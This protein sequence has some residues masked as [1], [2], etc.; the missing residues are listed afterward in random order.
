MAST[1][2]LL[3]I[4][5]LGA[6]ASAFGACASPAVQ[7]CGKSGVYCP[8]GTHCAA[9]QGICIPDANTCGDGHLD[10][11]E[12]CDDGNTLDG[13]GC[14]RDCKSDESCGNGQVDPTAHI[15]EQCDDGPNNSKL[16]D[17]CSAACQLVKCGNGV[18]EQGEQCDDSNITSGDGCS[19]TCQRE[20]CGNG[21]TDIAA[22]EVCD[23]GD[24]NGTPGDPCSANCRS[25]L[26]CGNKNVDPGEECDNGQV[27][28][29][30]LTGN[31]DGNDCR[32]D[33]Q[34]N[35]CGDGFIDTEPGSRQEECDDGHLDQLVPVPTETAGCNI[36]C[37]KE[38]CG[39]GK[40]NR[41]AGEQ[42]DDGNTTNN[43][44]CS[45]TCQ[46][47][48][49]G[50]GLLDPQEEC[51]GSAGLQPCN[52]QTCLQERCGNGIL[53]DDAR[54]GVHEQCDDHNTNNNDGCSSTCVIEFCGDGVTN[55]HEPCDPA[56]PQFGLA[57]CNTDCT[58][59]S[60]GD[61]KLNHAAG[62]QCDDGNTI[63]GDGC[64]ATC[65]FERCGNGVLD[66]EEQC[67][68]TLGLQPCNTQTCLQEI[69]GNGILD[70]DNAAGVH[71]QCD[72]GN[73]APG[74]GCSPTCQFEF[75]GDGIVSKGEACDRALTPATCNLDCTLSSCG[76]G[77]LNTSAAPPEQ[78][79]DGGATSGDGCSA[80]CQLEH[81]GN[82]VVDAFEECD[83]AAGLQPC[84]ASCHQERCG[85]G[86]LDRD[87]ANGI[88]EQCDDGNTANGDGCSATC[89]LERCGN[90]VLDPQEQCDGTLG[91]QPCNTQTCL[92]EICGNGILDRDSANGI[93][94]QCDDANTAP[95][96]GCSPDCHFETCGNGIKD[97]GE[98]CDDGTNNGTLSSQ[99]STTCHTIKCGNGVLEQG[100]DCDDNNQITENCP[101]GAT[102]C[103][104]CDKSCKITDGTTSLCG[105]GIV[106]MA[107]ACDDGNTSCGA[108]SSDCKAVTSEFALG[109]IVVPT[110]DHFQTGDT[111]V[112]SDGGTVAIFEFTVV[113]DA[114]PAPISP[115]LDIIP[116]TITN[117]A[118]NGPELSKDIATAIA[119]AIDAILQITATPQSQADGTTLI[120]LRHRFKTSNGNQPIVSQF[121][122]NPSAFQV[123]GMAGGR[124]GNCAATQACTQDADCASTH[125]VL[126]IIGPSVIGVC[127]P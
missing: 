7:E 77:K 38:K 63:N 66:P 60:C 59:T 71:E 105:D 1:N 67:D 108:C 37:T 56:D 106:D 51:D 10:P 102:S 97:P 126:P 36:D 5:F 11:G 15:P 53:D 101:Y 107:E 33:C 76:D 114:S 39:D 78:C 43:D 4:L 124:G 23:D 120:G 18:V 24:K 16:G 74:D 111:F 22:G 87:P 92:R 45:A 13:D 115:A 84:S 112:V 119:D 35:R 83:G 61:G 103:K 70:N 99:C 62:E 80:S 91:L 58:P 127:G 40:V 54:T 27:G 116:I 117:S 104:V 98:D 6:I 93:S 81:C 32:S 8:K 47:E 86:I 82:G 21:I 41:A 34:F 19:A 25:N 113:L 121:A 73:A 26:S 109:S 69:C 3:G 29:G 57:R 42:C 52:L 20:Y 2:R 48:R 72:D 44:G 95:G 100:E 79:D 122:E 14:S 88:S 68:G 28:P 9:V 89:Q 55:N 46:F 110:G 17:P 75:C 64:S 118:A 96:D 49:C 50:N 65:Q 94:E 123:F 31:Q 85:N 12:V 30:N 90:G 125:C